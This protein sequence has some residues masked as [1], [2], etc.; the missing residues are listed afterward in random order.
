M[1]TEANENRPGKSGIIGICNDGKM[2]V[3][4]HDVSNV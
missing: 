3:I 2:T 4:T 1:I